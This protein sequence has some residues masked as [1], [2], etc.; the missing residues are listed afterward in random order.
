MSTNRYNSQAKIAK[1][2]YKFLRGYSD[3]DARRFKEALD[4][5][6]V[7]LGKD[8]AKHNYSV[9]SLN[10]WF[11]SQKI[12]MEFNFDDSNGDVECKD[13]RTCT[14]RRTWMI[15]SRTSMATKEPNLYSPPSASLKED[16]KKRTLLNR[17]MAL[18]NH[19]YALLIGVPIAIVLWA[20]VLFM[21]YIDKLPPPPM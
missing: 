19:R 1:G 20:F 4:D 8:C 2:E 12:K 9:D 5:Y 15:G 17:A 14:S 21:A 11:P 6:I 3:E 10:G 16:G 18:F 13:P 7:E